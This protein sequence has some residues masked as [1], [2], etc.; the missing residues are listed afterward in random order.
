[1]TKKLILLLFPVILILVAFGTFLWRYASFVESELSV[2]IAFENLPD[3]LII[4]GQ[5]PKE[6]EVLVRGQKLVLAAFLEQKHACTLDLAQAT[7]GLVTL[8]I[9]ESN[10]QF[11]SGISIVQMEPT[12]FT[13]RI[14]P[15]LTKTVPVVVSLT[16]NTAPGYRVSLTLATPS[17]V[18]IVGSEK[19]L[20]QIDQLATLPVS[21]KDVSESFKKEIAV[22]LPNGVSI[23]GAGTSLVTA[24]VN[25]EENVIV[26]RF[27]DVPVE[28]RN[29][30]LPVKIT[31]PTIDIDVRGP[32]N[33]L[34]NLSV[35]DDIKAYVD[36]EGLAPGIYARSVSIP[37]NVG[38][39]TT[40]AG[41]DPKVFTVTIGN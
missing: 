34:S 12:S 38:T 16:D 4:V 24:N 27:E 11:P 14:E 25:I 40:V 2:P 15:K 29:T 41:Y 1:M 20:D 13:L 33:T 28:G 10:L 31:P 36:L 6:V 21:L 35:G 19:A 39:S 23:S 3:D 17:S 9:G 32:E 37:L 22:D 5:P 7:T 18:Q 8:P 26:R 30:V